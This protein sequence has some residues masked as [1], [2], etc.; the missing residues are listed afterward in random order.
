WEADLGWAKSD[1]MLGFT[2]AIL[3][4]AVFAPVYGK[5]I[6][7]GHGRWVLTGGAIA[8]AVLLTLLAQVTDRVE[9][10]TIWILI[11]AAQA[12]CLYEPC[13]AFVTKNTGASSRWAITRITLAAG[14]ASTLAFPAA[15]YL[16]E[17]YGWRLALIVFAMVIGLVAAPMMFAGAVM[18]ERAAPG[19]RKEHVPSVNRAAVRFAM[20]RVEFWLLAALFSFIS[21]NHAM[22][23]SHILP[24]IVDR[25]A[26]A[27]Q[28]VMAA[29]VIGPAQV[30]GRVVMMRLEK[31]V[32]IQTVTLWAISGG[33]LAALVLLLAGLFPMLV[34]VFALLQGA[35]FGVISILRQVMVAEILGRVAFGAIASRIAVPFLVSAATAPYIGAV[36]WR[37]GGYDL[38]V[39]TALGFVL[40]ALLLLLILHRYKRL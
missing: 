21:L 34:F 24:L 8:G 19:G 2:L 32:S 28:A 10:I 26:T 36:L 4:S 18:L 37:I 39:L 27:A 31:R 17:A 15:A 20:G 40:T 13:F 25:G 7:A 38:V 30:A 16:A 22:L 1:L 23:L 9:F 3:T 11:G 33:C 29:M 12:A 5:L 35:S 14:F 6:D